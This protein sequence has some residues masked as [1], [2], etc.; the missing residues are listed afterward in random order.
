MTPDTYQ[1][2]CAQ[3][4]EELIVVFLNMGMLA[5]NRDDNAIPLHFTNKAQILW[6]YSSIEK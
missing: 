1:D 2:W 5:S 3:H 4:H 6:L